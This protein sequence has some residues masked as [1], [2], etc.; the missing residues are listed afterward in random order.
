M[1]P[2]PAAAARGG[3]RLRPHARRWGAALLAVAALGGTAAGRV[4]VP[5]AGAQPAGQSLTGGALTGGAPAARATAAAATAPDKLLRAD[6]MVV[7]QRALPARDLARVARLR[8]VQAARTVDAARVRV[9]GTFAAVL[10]VDPATFRAFASGPTASSGPLWRNVAHGAIAVSYTMG[11]HDK[12]PLGGT[13]QVA[14]RTLRSL[15]VAGFG[16][17]GI[18]GVDAVVSRTVARS[19]GFPA[20]NAIVVSAPHDRVAALVREIKTRVPRGAVVESLVTTSARGTPA[21]AGVAGASVAAGTATS[22]TANGQAA[23]SMAELVAMLKAAA[24]RVGYPY[25]W[26][27]SGPTT[28]DCSGLVQ[29]S[30]RQAGVVMPRVAADQARTGPA[31]PFSQAQAGD[32]LFYRTDPTAPDYISHVAIYLGKGLMIQA[33]Q[34]GQ[35]VQI[36]PVALGS[37]FAGVVRVS[38]AIAAQ[39]AASPVG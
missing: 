16:T 37:E 26:G 17:V 8:G 30:Y 35:N 33:P 22:A 5:G 12:L 21:A 23:L 28:F 18:G 20:G 39:V 32:L 4:E 36:V 19:L 15:P 6:V 13:V 11:K 9:N 34:P 2:A 1:T 29:W 27:G 14:G 3:A 24:S 31:I 25:V 38:P 7:A 10:G